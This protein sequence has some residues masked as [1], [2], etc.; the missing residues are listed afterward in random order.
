[1]QQP[2]LETDAKKKKKRDWLQNCLLMK[3]Q[4]FLNNRLGTL[5]KG[6]PQ[7]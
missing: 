7:E 1:M 4:Q 6:P 2:N 5:S 3:N